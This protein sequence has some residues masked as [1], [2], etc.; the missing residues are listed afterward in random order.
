MSKLQETKESLVRMQRFE[1]ESLSR[2]SDLG[3]R[4]SLSAAV[5]PAKKLIR[6]YNQLGASALEDFPDDIL[7][8]IKRQA[9]AD[10]NRFQALLDFAPDEQQNPAS[11]RDQ[12]VEQITAA[13]HGA[14]QNLYMPIAYGASKS[15]D[16]QRM[17]NDARAS[18]QAV[19]DQATEI[20]GQLKVQHEQAEQI[21]SDVRKVA[22]EQ[23]VSQQALYFKDEAEEHRGLAA[24][25]QTYTVR[26]SIGVAAYALASL[27]LH[28]I[29]FFQPDSAFES[30]Q[31]IAS[32][33]LIFVVL[34]Y[35]LVLAA[36]NFLNHK[37][38]QI[39]NKHRQNALMTFKALV[40]ASQSE[41]SRDIVLVHAASCIFAPQ[42][43][44]YTKA[45]SSGSS[46]SVTE[47]LPK[48]VLRVDK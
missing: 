46:Q 45:Q 13:Y 4:F 30:A 40:D 38:N 6:L 15:I 25:W 10:F 36:K 22:A 28:K 9:D 14:F 17:E 31:L 44:G 16:F 26:L 1:A 39:V 24:T 7:D 48:T 2:E 27:F 18:L 47:L 3:A 23:G 42:D 21:L 11:V 19:T 43:T 37:H 34:S 8:Q 20:T 35:M 33:I 29:P 12:L 41:E 32:K 5:E